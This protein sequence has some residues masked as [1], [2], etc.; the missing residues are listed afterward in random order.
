M[1]SLSTAWFR[2]PD[3]ATAGIL[4]E[5]RRL[6][7]RAMEWAVSAA[8]LD[9]VEMTAAVRAGEVTVTSV[10]A[11]GGLH[12]DAPIN[13]QGGDLGSADSGKRQATVDA[14]CRTIDLA[15]RLGARAVVVHAG[16][17]EGPLFERCVH[18]MR[19]WLEVRLS[20]T[21]DRDLADLRQERRQAAPACLDR[22]VAS[23]EE[24]L[25][26]AGEFPLGLETRYVY[27]QL[28]LPDELERIWA[29]VGRG[30]LGYWHDV[31]HARIQQLFGGVPEMS[32]LDRFADRLLGVHLHDMNGTRDHRPPGQ[33]DLD[34]RAVADRVAGLDC[35]RVV[36][37]AGE[38]T[39]ADLVAGREHLESIG[40]T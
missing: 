33:G 23:L 31:G 38:F 34:L 5:V 11:L 21:L 7:F 8:R 17:I 13:L 6:G 39:A 9:E 40:L 1:L 3:L 4:A 37:V 10:H 18:M 12:G 26:R 20:P 35:L 36:E 22:I 2:S 27:C 24:V 16:G 29:S 25:C 28:P 15:R 14:L 19:H 32:W 30:C